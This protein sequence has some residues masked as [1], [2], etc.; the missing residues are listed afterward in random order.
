MRASARVEPEA[1]RA[2]RDYLARVPL[3]RHTLAAYAAHG[4]E[5]RSPF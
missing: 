1:P 5:E 4:E 3:A 2:E